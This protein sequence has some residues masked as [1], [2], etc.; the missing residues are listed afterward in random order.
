MAAQ[1]TYGWGIDPT[2]RSLF[3]DLGVEVTA[4]LRGAGLPDD[5]FAQTGVRLSNEEYYRLWQSLDAIV[6]DPLLPI[7]VGTTVRPETFSP[8]LFAALCS[9][10][11]MVASERIARFKPLIAPIRLAIEEEGS[12]VGF[13]LDWID[14]VPEPPSRLV[15]GELVF[16][17]N[18]IRTATRYRIVPMRVQMPETPSPRSAYRD[19]FGRMPTRGDRIG[20]VLD[21][22]DAERPFLTGSDEIWTTF[23]PDLRRH[24]ADL[25]RNASIAS[26]VRS[27]LLEALPS[28]RASVDE[29]AQML[30]TSRRTLQR[31]LNGEKTTFGSVLRQTRESLA[32]HYLTRTDLTSGEISWL[33]G[34]EEPNSFYRAVREWMG[35]TPEGVRG[36]P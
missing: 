2:W 1:T 34:F 29:V 36:A 13:Y 18:L 25:E 21:R 20:F 22:A 7:T 30:G 8:L 16:F 31:R 12:T 5:L 24:L 3:S 9:P 11:F 27:A 15:A 26:R 17:V 4:I 6:D 33:L 19:F 14:P 28:G 10:D 32:R 35:E 23:E